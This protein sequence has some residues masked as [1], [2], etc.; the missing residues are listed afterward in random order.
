MCDPTTAAIIAAAGLATSIGGT[1]MQASSN[2][3]AADRQNKANREKAQL[4][5]LAQEAE[6]KRQAEYQQQA[7]ANWNKELQAQGAGAIQGE[8]NT[9]ADQAQSTAN[10]VEKDTGITAGL[11]PGQTGDRVSQVFTKEA[12]EATNRR[13]ADAKTRIDAL[14]KLS[15][16]DRANGYSRITNN[17]FAA[18]QS[19]L[20]AQQRQSLNLGTQEGNI[21]AD[22]FVGSAG[23]TGS[24]IA[25]I[26]NAALGFAPNAKENIS[27]I[28]N[29]FSSPSP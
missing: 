26:G 15:G 2:A 23:N 12:A 1:V 28:A 25:G 6:R 9:G 7:E 29:I 21:T 19:L 14:A 17:R 11:L 10:Q 27:S 5:A 24:A 18:D 3:A 20:Q 16:F 4:S 13:M 8:I 22:T